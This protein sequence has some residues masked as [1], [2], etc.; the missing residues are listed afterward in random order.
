MTL[1]FMQN[2]PKYMGM[3][4]EKTHFVQKI[5]NSLLDM[6]YDTYSDY[7]SPEGL[8]N[9]LWNV[10][11]NYKHNVFLPKIHTIRRDE[12]GRWKP[13]MDIHFV[14]NS[15]TKDR[16][17]FAP[18]VKCKSVQTIEISCANHLSINDEYVSYYGEIEQ[19]GEKWGYALNVKIDGRQLGSVEV[20]KLA[21]ND[22]FDSVFDFYK[23]F[24]K[25]FKGRLIHWT[26]LKY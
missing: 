7:L 5:W 19:Y 24:E 9:N 10:L 22:G 21:K 18:V 4:N 1:G 11:V 26:D 20:E 3:Q 15:R 13:G 14:I 23:Y 6:D 17:Q 8:P 25:D 2:W 16:F 12:N